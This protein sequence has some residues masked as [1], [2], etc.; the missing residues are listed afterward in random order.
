M[1]DGPKSMMTIEMTPDA[2]AAARR[3]FPAD[4]PLHM[5]NLL[6]FRDTAAYPANSDTQPMTGREAYFQRYVPAFQAVAMEAGIEVKVAW[7]GTGAG[8]VA[9][10]PHERWDQIA[11]VEY[12]SFEDFVAIATSDPYHATAAEHRVAALEDLRLIATIQ[13]TP[14]A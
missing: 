10:L 5:L 2:L 4:Q 8:V 9:G 14:P 1:L 3:V 7:L 11:I 12:A 13:S 6:R